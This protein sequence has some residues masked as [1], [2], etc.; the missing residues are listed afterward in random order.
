M[1]SLRSTLVLLACV[2]LASCSDITTELVPAVRAPGS[3]GFD[4]DASPAPDANGDGDGSISPHAM[5]GSNICQCDDDVDNDADAL[6]DGLDPE[7]TAP[8]DNDEESFATGGPK[9]GPNACEDC[10]W[11]G[12]AD[13]V[14]DGCTYTA[15]CRTSGVLDGAGGPPSSMCRSCEVTPRCIDSCRGSTPNGC[16]CF[17]CCEITRNDGT[18]AHVVL[19]DECSVKRV[20]DERRC[21]VCVQ[22][23]EC[24]NTC[25]R[26]ELCLGKKMEDLP[27]DCMSASET[28]PQ[29]QCDEGYQACSAESPCADGYYCVLGCCLVAVF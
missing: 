11:D 18:L 5:C 19:N 8:F 6:A 29:H 20:D 7:C 12:N 25:G 13:T 16:D 1:S 21:P 17:G 24:L 15:A 3:G 23:S 14:D 28:D 4:R 27:A 26:C 2:L 9:A 10:F 22:N